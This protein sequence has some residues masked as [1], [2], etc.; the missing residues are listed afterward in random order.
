[1][2]LLDHFHPP[3]K[4]RLPWETLHA[5]WAT[6]L[7]DGLNEILPPGFIA[8]ERKRFASS[9]EIDIGTYEETLSKGS[10]N[11]TAAVLEAPAYSPPVPKRT[12]VPSFADVTEVLVYEDPD[13]PRLVGAIELVSPRNK[14]RPAAV[15]AFVAK[16][17]SYIADGASVIVVDVVTSRRANLHT[18]LMTLLGQP[19]PADLPAD[20]NLYVVAYRPMLRGDEPGLQIWPYPLA[21][22]E[23]L[24]TVPLRLTGDDFVPVDLESTYAETC[25]RRR[26]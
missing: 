1:V 13:Q 26:L 5:A 16:C 23:P 9:F 24:P 7:A 17:A 12:A 6:H 11:G 22:G 8:L 21:L 2:P 15:Q 10:A 25:R 18:E 3:I 14:D 4:A 19:D 20:S